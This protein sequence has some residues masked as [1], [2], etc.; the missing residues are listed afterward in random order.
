MSILVFSDKQTATA[1]AATVLASQLIEK[2]SAVLGFEYDEALLPVYHSLCAMT[3]N[4]LLNWGNAKA[5][6]L[7]EFV[8]GQGGASIRE[9]MDAVLFHELN[10]PEENVFSPAGESADWAKSC[11]SFENALLDAGGMD[12]ALLTLKEGGALL[13]NG[14]DGEIAPITHVELYKQRKTVTAGIS[15]LMLSK[16]I[17]VVI[18]GKEM[19]ETAALAIKGAVTS[20]VPASLLQLHAA[21]TF[22][23]DEDAASLLA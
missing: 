9:T 11:Q 5:F 19:A 23:L 6:Q 22:L 20:A 16:K 17:L 12:M 8:A 1:A 2:P 3:D 15:T 7:S 13:F 14:A 10:I 4:G 21:S 18:T